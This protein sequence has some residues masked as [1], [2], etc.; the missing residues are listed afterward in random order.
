MNEDKTPTKLLSKIEVVKTLLEERNHELQEFKQDTREFQKTN[1]E[2][3]RELHERVDELP[4][5]LVSLL[6]PIIETERKK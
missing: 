5:T 4:K 6:I 2:Q 1:L 3:H